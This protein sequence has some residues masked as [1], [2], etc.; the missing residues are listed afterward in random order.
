M[1][2]DELKTFVHGLYPYTYYP[3]KFPT[4][5]K[6]KCVAIK[7]T[8]GFPTDQWTGKRQ[9]S[10]Q[11]LVRGDATRDG[12]YGAEGVANAIKSELTNLSE[13]T[14]GSDSVV[15]IRCMNSDPLYVGDDENDRPI[16]SLNFDMVVRQ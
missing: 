2:I 13:I 6:D 11:V 15:I 3:N 7:L 10:F 9:P 1:T 12:L 8:G 5:A 14:I 16:Y 4:G